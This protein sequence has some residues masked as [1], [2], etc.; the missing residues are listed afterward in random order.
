EGK[1]KVVIESQDLIAAIDSTGLCVFTL[2]AGE[3]PEHYAAQVDAA[4][5]G[6]WDVA[7]LL[8]TGERVWNLE[9]QFNI[10]AGLDA[11]HDTL[12]KRIL[13]EP[14]PS[15]AAKGLVAKL[16]EMLPQYYEM[17]GWSKDGKPENDTLSRLGLN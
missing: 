10:A 11:Q 16:P 4:C 12:P 1:A 2:H 6:G 3:S 5:G 14:A 9:R 7:R 13:E 8:E 15:G 17:R